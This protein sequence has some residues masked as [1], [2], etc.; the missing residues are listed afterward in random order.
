MLLQFV[1]LHQ[2]VHH[3][4]SEHNLSVPGLKIVNEDVVIQPLILVC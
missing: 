4:I 2:V 3:L 1:K